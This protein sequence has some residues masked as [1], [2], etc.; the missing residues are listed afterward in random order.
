MS[1]FLAIATVTECLRQ[2]V[3]QGTQDAIKTALARV[4]RPPADLKSNHPKEDGNV[5]VGVYLYQVAPNVAFRNAAMPTRRSDGSVV[6]VSRTAYD[7]NFLVSFYGDDNKLE[8]QRVM[9]AVLRKLNAQPILTKETIKNAKKSLADLVESDLEA[10]V[11]QVKFS[12]LPLSLDEL[13]KLWS[14]FFQTS[15]LLSVGIQA[16]V[17]FIDGRETARP[18]LPVRSRNLYVRLINAPVIEQFLSQPTPVD[19]PTAERA[20]VAGDTLVISGKNLRGEVTRLRLGG[21]EVTPDR[22]MQTEIVITLKSPPFPPDTLRAGVQAV[23]VVQDIQMGAPPRPH[24]GFESNVAAFV[25]C[26][27]VTPGAVTITK[28]SI[29]DSVTFH[30]ANLALAFSP[31]V[32]VGQRVTLLLNELDPPASR[33]AYA[34]RFNVPVKPPNPADKSVAALAATVSNVAK[35]KYLVRVQVDGAESVLSASPDPNDARFNNPQVNIA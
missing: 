30:N 32:G 13:S 7:L 17:V 31:R 10:E 33:P 14:V 15:Y 34:Y 25:L 8:P 27:T 20:I 12:I 11:E 16:S 21:V 2:I 23:Q 29:V 28:T 5:F 19:P 6:Q 1:N 22:V 35:G 24:A 26:P 4:I 18:A 9:G 3:E